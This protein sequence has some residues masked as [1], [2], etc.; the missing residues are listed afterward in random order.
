MS[1]HWVMSA[2]QEATRQRR[3]DQLIE[4]SAQGLDIPALR[5]T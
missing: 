2:K 1:L 5:R 3:L 4:N